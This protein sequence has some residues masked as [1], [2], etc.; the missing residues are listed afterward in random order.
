MNYTVGNGSG[1]AS[2]NLMEVSTYPFFT[3]TYSL[4]FLMGLVLNGFTVRVYFCRAQR[5]QSSVTVYLQNL[6]A[7]DFFL[8]LCL[9]LRI[10]NY[11]THNSALMRHVYCSFGATAFYLNMYASILFMDYIA[12]NRYLKIVRPLE[13]HALQTVRAAHYISMATWVTLLALSSAYLTVSLLTTWGTDPIP[14]TMGCDALHSPQLLLL[15][16][17]IHSF[18]AAIFLFVLFSLLFLYWATIRR[19]RQVQ[20][21][22]QNH[23]SCGSSRKLS[24]SKRNMLV[25]V[26]VFCVCFVPYHLVRLPYAFLQPFLHRCV[27]KQAFYYLKELTVLLS[28]LNACLDP[29]I[30]FIFCKAFRAQLGLK[31]VFSKT[32]TTAQQDSTA[33]PPEARRISQGNLTT[34]TH[35]QTR[36]SFS[37]SRRG[38]VI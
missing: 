20:L 23:P 26:A 36:T 4:V 11:A 15:Y 24:S 13:T 14:G 29:L 31:I 35:T 38:S 18:S 9:P 12:A 2:C 17:I 27:W 16:K 10:A 5:H 3:V 21:N 34:L 8:S 32:T 6:A 37:M 33:P 25:L 19:L 1:S 30:Y 22:Q 7:A 28:V